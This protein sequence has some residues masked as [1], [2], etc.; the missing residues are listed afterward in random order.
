MLSVLSFPVVT[1]ALVGL[2]QVCLGTTSDARL[3]TMHDVIRPSLRD[4][5][6]GTRERDKP[7]FNWNAMSALENPFL[8]AL[9]HPSQKGRI[10]LGLPWQ[11]RLSQGCGSAAPGLV[12]REQV[13]GRVVCPSNG[14]C[15]LDGATPGHPH[16]PPGLA[17]S[18]PFLDS[19]SAL[20]PSPIPSWVSPTLPR[21]SHSS[22]HTP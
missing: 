7:Q 9:F 10:I 11:A 6:F 15:A 1:A 21:R 17:P 18:A 13:S 2:S 20:L 8:W 12:C 14:T 4:R 3:N 16:P 5:G 19:A 22:G